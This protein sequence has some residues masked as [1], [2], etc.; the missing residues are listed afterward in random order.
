MATLTIPNTF[1]NETPADGTKVNQNF[2]AVETVVN[3]LNDD[4]VDDGAFSE[5]KTTFDTVGGHDHDGTNSKSIALATNNAAQGTMKFKSGTTAE[6]ADDATLA[7]VFPVDDNA[8]T[9]IPIVQVMSDAGAIYPYAYYYKYAGETF[10]SG[11]I[12]GPQATHFHMIV[13]PGAQHTLF[14]IG[15][16]V[17]LLSALGFTIRNYTGNPITVKWQ[18]IGI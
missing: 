6:I 14:S 18:A 2:D 1:V 4:N 15:I 10:T 13:V 7:I 9:Q 8:F 16:S 17:D 3:D 12:I 11:L 5:A